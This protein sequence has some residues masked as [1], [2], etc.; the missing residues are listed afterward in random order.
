MARETGKHV[1]HFWVLPGI[2]AFE[3]GGKLIPAQHQQFRIE[4]L[5]LAREIEPAGGISGHQSE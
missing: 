4:R 5:A 2:P 1:A 3:H